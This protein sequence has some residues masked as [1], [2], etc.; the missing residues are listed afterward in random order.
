[1][2]IADKFRLACIG[3]LADRP[4]Y[5]ALERVETEEWSCDKNTLIFGNPVFRQRYVLV[6]NPEDAIAYFLS[7]KVRDHH[8]SVAK[9]SEKFFERY[10]GL[11]EFDVTKCLEYPGW[12]AWD[13]YQLVSACSSDTLRSPYKTSGN[14]VRIFE[15]WLLENVGEAVFFAQPDLIN[16][17]VSKHVEAYQHLHR[18][19]RSSDLM[20]N[21]VTLPQGYPTS[22]AR[23]LKVQV[24]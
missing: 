2:D 3:S 1:M 11:P 5:R 9:T 23:P 4:L 14:S 8:D 20:M 12:N 22:W 17:K 10:K 16:R 24:Y 13:Y 7:K 15:G 19:D 18:P 6:R 21:L